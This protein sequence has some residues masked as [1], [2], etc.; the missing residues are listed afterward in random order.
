[1]PARI[2]G[3][4][5]RIP[6]S[7]LKGVAIPQDATKVVAT[8]SHEISLASNQGGNW[9]PDLKLTRRTITDPG[10]KPKLIDLPAAEVS[11]L[12]TAADFK[13][14]LTALLEA[15]KA[16]L[17]PDKATFLATLPEADRSNFAFINI[18]GRRNDQFFDE[19]IKLLSRTPL[20]G[21]E[22]TEARKA[23]NLAHRD[24]FRGRA[25]DY[26][27]ADT[28]SYW[29]YGHDAPFVH[30]FEEMLKALP[31]DD[32]RRKGVQNQVDFIFTHKYVDG[33]SMREHDAEKSMGLVAMDKTSRHILSMTKASEGSN[34]V[35]Y[36]TLQ[37]PANAGGEHAGKFVYRDGDKFFFEKSNTAVPADLVAKLKSTPAS[38]VVFR[39]AEGGEAPRS[40]FAYD[41]DGNRRLNVENINTGWWGHCDIK[42]MMEVILADMK[43]SGGVQEFRSDTG[44]TTNFTRAM[45]LEGLAS[46]LNFDDVYLSTRGGGAVR[47]GT[48][49]FAGGRFDDRPTK[50]AVKTDRGSVNFDI[51]ITS[52]AD[53][54]DPTKTVD[55]DKAFAP[56][57]ADDKRENFKDNPDVRLDPS[58]PDTTH[59]NITGRK[60]SGTTDGYTFDNLGRPVQSKTPFT[61]D[62]AATTGE[63][64]L[65]GTE[66]TNIQGRQLNRF[67]Y[68][69][70]TKEISKVPTSFVKENGATEYTAKEGV[71]QK[72]G[73]FTGAEV[74]RELT[75]GDDVKGKY[76]MLE[77]AVR[78]GQKI[79][80]DSDVREQVWNGEVHGIRMDTAWRSPDG[81][82]ER[83][84]V[85]VDATFGAGKTGSYLNKLDDEGKIIDQMELSPVV[86]FF[87]QDEPRIAPLISE[88]GNWLVNRSMYERGVISTGG[89]MM[90]STGALQ[91]LND[92]VYLGLK[93]KDSKPVYTIVHEGKR[94]V[95]P[96]EAAWKADIARLKGTEVGPGP[97]PV[98]KVDKSNTPNLA[99]PD[100]LPAGVADAIKVEDA[101]KLAGIRIN[102]DL[103]HTWVGDLKLTLVAPDGT[104]LALHDKSGN[105]ADNI[106]GT[107]GAELK[108]AESLDVLKG[109][110][111]KGDWKLKVQDLAG[112][113]VGTLK[114][115]GL[116]LDVQ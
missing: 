78:S 84:D 49:D 68:D 97:G 81:K 113:D 60:L 13:T 71:A 90:S 24:A 41:W 35:S 43:G 64:V 82:W 19:A 21:T 59:L 50:M 77:T 86:D 15:N 62:P 111:I 29:S 55:I 110:D 92:L 22:A 11:G 85:R 51:R 16:F 8:S 2:D 112:Q 75:G 10:A 66:L 37:V 5:P 34:S 116:S 14:K 23:V 65:V 67:Y 87:W 96:D 36:E 105:S 89:E 32:P 25:V 4:R 98:R 63:K 94:L 91:D 76:R 7:Q 48:G 53:K 17:A 93:T 28:G 72:V 3:N 30:V 26:D 99:I 69:P 56:K 6:L 18:I 79:A 88:R 57:M 95:Y 73:K 44:V 106:K 20:T 83:V 109:K 9:L 47:M 104:E 70:A 1:M 38:E 52:I 108:A 31:D 45:Q 102:I 33:G 107:F 115:W 74:S 39:R 103:E 58:D 40:N 42:A 101:G 61:I 80:T 54:A 100:N 12:K 27:R 114:S 46:L